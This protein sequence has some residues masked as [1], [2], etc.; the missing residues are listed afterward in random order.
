MESSPHHGAENGCTATGRRAGGCR[1][2]LQQDKE[3][4]PGGAGAVHV[5]AVGGLQEYVGEWLAELK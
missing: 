5:G 1:C 4:E 3:A 2:E